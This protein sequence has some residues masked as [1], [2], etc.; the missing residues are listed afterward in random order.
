[1]I[2]RPLFCPSGCILE[3]TVGYSDDD[4][5]D[6]EYYYDDNYER[7]GAEG[8]LLRSQLMFPHIVAIR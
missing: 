6:D 2:S 5:S 7:P 3:D 1:M 8:I 4:N